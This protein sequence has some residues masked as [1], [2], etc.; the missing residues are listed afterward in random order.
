LNPRITAPS[1]DRMVAIIEK[2]PDAIKILIM[3]NRSSSR[4]K[5]GAWIL[6]LY[7]ALRVAALALGSARQFERPG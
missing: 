1:G 2:T 3:K 6:S 5:H 7:A 4:L